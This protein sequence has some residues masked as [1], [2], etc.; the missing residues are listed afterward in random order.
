MIK[1]DKIIGEPL[2]EFG[3]GGQSFDIRE[4]ITRYGPVD[5]ATPRAK[6]EVKIGLVGTA[7]SIEAFS[8]WM[9]TCANGIKGDN[10]LN[11]NLNPDFPGLAPSV[12]FRAKFETHES[13]VSELS[14]RELKELCEKD[15]AVS[16]LAEL[17]HDKI[18]SL[19][20][21]SASKPDVVICLPPDIVRKRV[22]PRA[23]ENEEFDDLDDS[24]KGVDFHDYLK[25]R[26]LV[27][28]SLFQLVWPRTYGESAREVQ[29]PATRAWNL[30]GGLFYKAGGIPWKLLRPPSGKRTCY[31]GISFSVREEGGYMHSSLTQVFNDKG[32]GTILRGG[33]A[34]KSEEDHEVH[35]SK[36]AAEKLLADAIQNYKKA[37]DDH[38]PDRVVVHK[39]SGYDRAELDGFNKA[40]DAVGVKFCDLVAL[41]RSDIRF[42][43]HG[44]YPPLRGS[45]ILLDEMN[46]VLYTRGSVPFYRKYPGPYVPRPLHVRY[47]QT[48]RSQ[49]ELALEILALTKLN[50]NKTQFDSLYPITLGGSRRIGE[51]YKWCHDPPSDPL[52]YAFFM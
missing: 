1:L 47:F 32:E 35:L 4:G 11:P 16:L 25:G 10:P 50:W 14:E 42:F 37:N 39:S 3:S 12:G 24:E 13:W 28:R 17:F 26:C 7:K 43:R 23:Y 48:E 15:G 30:F 6:T 45:H 9:R 38:L 29:D 44:S 19:F 20:E 49:T 18:R 36:E 2:L 21:L 46:S 5:V 31:V 33:M 34:H 52:S 41:N 40:A 27:S 51:I 8:A 22:K